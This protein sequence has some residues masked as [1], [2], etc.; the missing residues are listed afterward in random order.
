[1]KSAK[2]TQSLVRPTF[3]ESHT[4]LQASPTARNPSH[5]EILPFQNGRSSEPLEAVSRADHSGMPQEST[6]WTL[7]AGSSFHREECYPSYDR[8]HIRPSI[9]RRSP[10]DP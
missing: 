7:V 10:P 4:P 9:A 3:D 5:N 2:L 6:R 1:M 8:P